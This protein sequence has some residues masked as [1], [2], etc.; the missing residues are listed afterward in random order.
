MIAD[1]QIDDILAALMTG[2]DVDQYSA[3]LKRLGAEAVPRLLHHLSHVQTRGY[4]LFS[5]QHCWS[6]EALDPVLE[7]LTDPDLETRRMA[8]V[9]LDRHKGREYVARYCARHIDHPNADVAAFCFEHAEFMFPDLQRTRWA[10]ERP[11][12][13]ERAARYLARYYSPALHA[14]TRALLADESP[15]LVRAALIALI[16]QHD[17][18]GE[19]RRAVLRHLGHVHPACRD[20]AAEYLAWHGT[21]RELAMLEE[22]AAQEPEARARASMTD[23]RLCIERRAGL[24]EDSESVTA[25]AAAEG[26]ADPE[27]AYTQARQ[28]L[29]TQQDAAAVEHARGVLATAEPCDPHWFFKG[30]ARPAGG[31]VAARRARFA[32][33]ALLFAMPWDAAR[34]SAEDPGRVEPAVGARLLLPTR[35]TL[36]EPKDGFGVRTNPNDRAFKQLVHV[37]DDVSWHQDHAC[38]VALADGIVRAVRC[39]PSWGG[40]VIVEHQ[41]DC[42]A[43]P[44]VEELAE[45]FSE[46]VEEPLIGPNGALRVCSLYAHLGPFVRVRPG[47]AITAG[48]KIGTIGRALTWENGGYPAH[49]H[50]GLHLGPYRQTPRVGSRTDINFKD[51]RYRGTVVKVGPAGIEAH[52]RHRGDPHFLVTRPRGWEC[53][54]IARWYWDTDSHGWVGAK[55]LLRRYG[56]R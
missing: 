29:E 51:K 47:Q 2:R 3:L 41:L 31:F 32:L 50:L 17:R 49:L 21:S 39:Q 43:L 19:T 40:L 34:Q 23:A 9:V 8:A 16:H 11:Q 56:G 13:R 52:I 6:K 4:A 37:G 33:Q 5:L 15:E 27:R 22:A 12:L 54:Y 46:A 36:L 10:L 26:F 38:V 25:T 18:S 44:G 20:A 30:K 28:R 48:E 53:G 7:L 55:A 24:L 42:D 1:R 45:G 14:V 35:D